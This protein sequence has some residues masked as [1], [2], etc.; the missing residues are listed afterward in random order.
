MPSDVRQKYLFI[1][2]LFRKGR[3]TNCDEFF[4][5]LDVILPK[6]KNQTRLMINDSVVVLKF[7]SC[8][9]FL[10]H[11]ICMFYLTNLIDFNNEY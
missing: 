5:S 3:E 6:D 9:R 7:S 8:N 1:F 10:F 2:F 4:S 11:F